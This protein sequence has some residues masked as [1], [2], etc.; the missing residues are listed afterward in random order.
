MDEGEKKERKKQKPIPIDS[1]GGGWRAG[2]EGGRVGEVCLVSW[3]EW[4]EGLRPRACLRLPCD[5]V[6]YRQYSPAGAR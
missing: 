3:D 5:T 4:D 1:M 6:F 2:R